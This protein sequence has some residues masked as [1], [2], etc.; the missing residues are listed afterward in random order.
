T[1]TAAP[2]G[3]TGNVSTGFTSTP[4]AAKLLVF[5]VQPSAAAAGAVIT[6]AVQV[7]ARDSRGNTATGFTGAVTIAIGNNP[8]GGALS[9]TTNPSAVGGGATFA[10]LSS[11]QAGA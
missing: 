3:R 7:T 6:P 1:V 4:R 9:G 2:T 10:D 8:G 11:D 5:T